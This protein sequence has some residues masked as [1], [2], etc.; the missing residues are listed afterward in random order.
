M[1]MKLVVDGTEIPTTEYDEEIIFILINGAATS[2]SQVSEYWKE[3]E[4][5]L[6]RNESDFSESDK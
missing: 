4:L 2:F 1:E 5:K 6:K 3:L